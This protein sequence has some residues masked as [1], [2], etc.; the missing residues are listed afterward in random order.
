MNLGG[1]A[2]TD[3]SRY[4]RGLGTVV[5]SHFLTKLESTLRVAGP[6]LGGERRT[7]IFIDSLCPSVSVPRQKKIRKQNSANCDSD[8]AKKC[9]YD[10][11]ELTDLVRGNSHLFQAVT[12]LV[13]CVLY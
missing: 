12:F 1:G 5:K 7:T 9:Y 4:L 8:L 13:V 11:T 6:P 10:P 3:H 2:Q